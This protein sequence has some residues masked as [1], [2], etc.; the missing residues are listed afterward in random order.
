VPTLLSRLAQRAPSIVANSSTS[1]GV[2]SDGRF[3]SPLRPRCRISA[4]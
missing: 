3:C 2:S 1:R 4:R